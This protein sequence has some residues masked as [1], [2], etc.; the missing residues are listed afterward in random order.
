VDDD[1]EL[2]D[3][4]RQLARLPLDPRVGRMIL[5]AVKRQALTEVLVIASALSG[6]D[7]RDRPLDQQQAAD[8]KH[9]PFDDEKSEF[10]GY[11]KLWKW[12]EEGRGHGR[13][14]GTPAQ[15]VSNRQQEQ[16]LRESFVSPRRVREWRDIHSQLHTVVAEHGWR[17]NAYP[18]P[19]SR[20]TWRCWPGCW[21]TSAA[22]A[23]TTTGTWAR[24]A[25]SSGATRART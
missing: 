22:R 17:L 10:M 3:I 13:W 24:A 4:G 1:N 12:I 9:K 6:Q 14:H 15:A 19:T 2:T 20:C 8:E 5:E 11:L 21:A 16:R 25:S 23:T 18:P 7:V